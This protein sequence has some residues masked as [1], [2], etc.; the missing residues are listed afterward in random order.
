MAEAI[1]DSGNVHIVRGSVDASAG[2]LAVITSPDGAA[3]LTRTAAGNY[4]INFIAAFRAAPNVTVTAVKANSTTVITS[5]ILV[6][7]AATAAVVNIVDYTQAAT[8]TALAD[9]DFQF[10]AIGPRNR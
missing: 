6:S 1:L 3:T 7:V 2:T 10:I 8:I 5:A 4:T 9:H